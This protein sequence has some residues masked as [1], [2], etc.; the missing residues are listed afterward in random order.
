MK[1]SRFKVRH[2]DRVL[3]LAGGLCVALVT[4]ATF[5]VTSLVLE[6]VTETI[7]TE[8]QMSAESMTRA[9][10]RPLLGGDY[11]FA[12]R[13]LER[14]V[15][16][17]ALLAFQIV[18]G[19]K[20]QIVEDPDSAARFKEFWA[21]AQPKREEEGTGAGMPLVSATGATFIEVPIAVEGGTQERVS[22]QFLYST[23]KIDETFLWIRA[24]N[25]LLVGVVSSLLLAVLLFARSK[26]ERGMLALNNGIAGFLVSG[27]PVESEKMI[28]DEYFHSHERVRGFREEFF[29]LQDQ[30]RTQAELTAVARTTQALAHDVRKPFS[31]LRSIVH[32]VE[33][34]DD[35]EEARDVLLSTLP[36]IDQAMSSVEGMIQDVMQVG[37][38]LRLHLEDVSPRELIESALK[39]IKRVFPDAEVKVHYDFDHRRKVLADVARVSRVF[40]NLIG[41]A[42]QA[43][44]GRGDVTFRT[45][46]DREFVAFAVENSGSYIDE[47]D[48]ARLFDA[49]FTSGKRGG[50]GLGLAI[51]KK[52]VESHGGRIL[53]E[54]KRGEDFPRGVTT[55]WF[56]LPASSSSDE[57]GTFE[58]PSV[59]DPGATSSDARQQGGQTAP[60]RLDDGTAASERLL[61]DEMRA[62]DRRL[63]L[64]IVDD[65]AVYRQTLQSMVKSLRHLE[66][67]VG[68]LSASNAKDAVR[69]T[70]EQRPDIVIMDFDLGDP[71]ED[72][73]S[74]T[75]ALRDRGFSGC[76]C[77]HSNRFLDGDGEAALAAGAN[78][79]L[80]KPIGRTSL[81]HLLAESIRDGAHGKHH[82][83]RPSMR[84]T[85]L[86][87]AVVE[88]SLTMR[89]AWQRSLAG[90]AVCHAFAGTQ[91]FFD[92]CFQQ[93]DFLS[94]LSVVVTDFR[95]APDDP[96][97]GVTFAR[98]IRAMGFDGPILRASGEPTMSPD[99]EG[100][101]DAS[102]GKR[103]LGWQELSCLLDSL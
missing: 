60:S 23:S 11:R 72:G 8:Q 35:A 21:T 45:R 28:L 14:S 62:N 20:R 84:A 46:D 29:R 100:I 73:V 39:D 19:R 38:E 10:T 89:V 55:F 61:A 4:A 2:L 66:G 43:V 24:L 68:F 74:L 88:D 93:A 81:L 47:A 101:F 79:V 85:P 59:V 33:G 13:V 36:E 22:V 31:M 102:V 30:V 95:F 90:G 94:E 32:A 78:S 75:K 25:I 52:I 96:H 82:L 48:R 3:L 7:R 83:T 50:T 64:L 51:T 44:S 58:L 27:R 9:L 98:A 76:I 41:N 87:V 34:I 18:D 1:E 15:D 26:F 69:I 97:D 91:E 17:Q 53:C 42:F 49:F 5:G 67:R 77:L 54:S 103:A 57:G 6:R 99:L 16:D 65:E 86:T 56:T 71:L 40:A 37:S 12:W 92:R 63:K 70:L 80:P